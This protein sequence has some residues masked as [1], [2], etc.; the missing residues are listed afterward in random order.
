MA[1]LDDSSKMGKFFAGQQMYDD[2][3]EMSEVIG[4]EVFFAGVRV[5]LN[6]ELPANTLSTFDPVLVEIMQLTIRESRAL[7]L[8]EQSEPQ[9]H[10]NP[11][12]H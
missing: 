2:L 6:P 4:G 10:T 9:A 11:T 8:A 7:E 5:V 12:L 1:K 3:K